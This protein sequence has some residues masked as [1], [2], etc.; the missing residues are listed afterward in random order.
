MGVLLQGLAPFQERAGAP[1]VSGAVGRAGSAALRP[2]WQGPPRCASPPRAGSPAL[3]RRRLAPGLSVTSCPWPL[4]SPRQSLH[5]PE[6]HQTLGQASTA[7]QEAERRELLLGFGRA[8]ERPLPAS[9]FPAVLYLP[10][11]T[12]LPLSEFP[13][14]A[15]ILCASVEIFQSYS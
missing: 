9:S 4:G 15:V 1:M 12:P 8:L 11:R 5:A 3:P 6:G 13:W 7:G 14:C 10:V 2:A